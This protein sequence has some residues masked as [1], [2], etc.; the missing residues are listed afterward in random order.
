MYKMEEISIKLVWSM[1]LQQE[2]VGYGQK[3]AMTNPLESR[4]NL[5][6]CSKTLNDC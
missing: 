4:E 6:L 1:K 5:I 2:Q 3:K